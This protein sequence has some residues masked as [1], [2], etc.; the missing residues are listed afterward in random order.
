MTT[1]AGERLTL[2]QAIAGGAY[3][4]DGKRLF[5]VVDAQGDQVRLEDCRYPEESPTWFPVRQVCETMEL[6]RLSRS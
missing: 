5:R 1:A 2:K 6:V 3:L 4:Q